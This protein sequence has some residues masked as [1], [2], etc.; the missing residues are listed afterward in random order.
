MPSAKLDAESA[1]SSSLSRLRVIG[2]SQSCWSSNWF[3]ILRVRHGRCTVYAVKLHRLVIVSSST[4]KSKLQVLKHLAM[5]SRDCQAYWLAAATCCNYFIRYDEGYKA[6]FA[7]YT[8]WLLLSS[9]DF[10]L[11]DQH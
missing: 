7:F 8:C 3:L 5:V 2:V 1:L 9:C 11:R 4:I 6:H 10:A